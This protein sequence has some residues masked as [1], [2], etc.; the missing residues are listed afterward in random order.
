MYCICNKNVSKTC[1]KTSMACNFIEFSINNHCN[2]N[3]KYD[4]VFMYA[5]IKERI[6]AKKILG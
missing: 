1:L 4:K 3:L 6:L 5:K 2:D